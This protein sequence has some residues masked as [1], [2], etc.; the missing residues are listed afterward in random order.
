MNL[1]LFVFYR[2]LLMWGRRGDV[3][4]RMFFII[5]FMEGIKCVMLLDNFCFFFVGVGFFLNGF[6]IF[7][8]FL[9]LEDFVSV[10]IKEIFFLGVLLVVM[11]MGNVE[12]SVGNLYRIG[13]NVGI[14]KVREG[15]GYIEG[16]K[17]GFFLRICRVFWMVLG[18]FLFEVLLFCSFVFFRFCLCFWEVLYS[19]KIDWVFFSLIKKLEVFFFVIFLFCFWLIFFCFLN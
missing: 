15:W 18:G 17:W 16:V 4:L 14:L 12:V 5:V 3:L 9:M 6:L 13:L 2:K 1:G 7:R 11:D 19:W 10:G 8:L